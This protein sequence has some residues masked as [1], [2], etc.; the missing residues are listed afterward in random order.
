[1]EKAL[2]KAFF[3]L[4]KLQVLTVYI[5]ELCHTF[6]GDK[7]E[8]FSYAITEALEIVLN[9]SEIIKKYKTMWENLEVY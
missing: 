2:K 1:M 7:Y 8:S 6:G 5:H 4:R 9:N 3:Y